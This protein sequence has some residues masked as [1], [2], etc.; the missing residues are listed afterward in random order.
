MLALAAD[1]PRAST[2]QSL[3]EQ[4]D[5]PRKFLEAILSDLRR[6]GLV[7]SQRGAEGGYWLARPAEAISAGDGPLAEVRGGRPEHAT[8]TGAAVH[9]QTVWVAVR[10]A[11]RGVLDQVSLG[12]VV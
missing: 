6:A 8:Y 11:V 2:A 10:A 12:D 9:L 3:A 1:E 4:Q 7:R 5:L